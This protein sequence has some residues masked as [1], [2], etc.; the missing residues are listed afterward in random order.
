MNIFNTKP[1]RQLATTVSEAMK[2][3][4]DILNSLE[5]V[6]YVSEDELM[7]IRASMVIL[8]QREEALQSE[9]EKASRNISLI[10]AQFNV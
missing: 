4:Q 9:V 7:E 3:I 6:V 5:N 2:P 10:K 1:Q 8:Q